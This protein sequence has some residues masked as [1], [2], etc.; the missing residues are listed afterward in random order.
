MLYVQ[1]YDIIRNTVGVKS[2][3]HSFHICLVLVVPAALVIAQR[4]EWRKSLIACWQRNTKG[5]S[6]Y[7]YSHL[8]FTIRAGA[9]ICN[10]NV[11]GF[12]CDLKKI[13]VNEKPTKVLNVNF[14]YTTIDNIW[15]IVSTCELS[16]LREHLGSCG[17]Q[18]NETVDCA[19]L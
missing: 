14:C 8:L 9:D 4:E 7:I 1:P 17:S 10:F 11:R 18:Q 5:T 3:I 13:N 12:R 2:S 16:V 15:G 19:A 6:V